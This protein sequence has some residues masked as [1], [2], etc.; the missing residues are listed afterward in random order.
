[1]TQS[2]LGNYTSQCP[3]IDFITEIRVVEEQ[4]RSSIVNS[5]IVVI[6]CLAF[7]WFI[8]PWVAKVTNLRNILL[9]VNKYIIGFNVSV[10]NIF[11]MKKIKAF[12]DLK[13]E[14]FDEYLRKNERVAVVKGNQFL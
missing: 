6:F 4:F 3:D 7:R 5:A 1:M 2:H 10:D 12:E 13:S 8:S 11:V 9:E 14:E